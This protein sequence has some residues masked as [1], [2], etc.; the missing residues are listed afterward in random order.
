MIMRPQPKMQPS[1]FLPWYR[2]R[3]L[4]LSVHMCLSAT[5][6]SKCVLL[7]AHLPSCCFPYPSFPCLKCLLNLQASL[8]YYLTISW[9]SILSFRLNCSLLSAPEGCV[10]QPSKIACHPIVHSKFSQWW[11]HLVLTRALYIN[12]NSHLLNMKHRLFFF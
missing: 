8:Q 2:R 7:F 3:A 1:L 9:P 6:I 4:R 5:I 11:F 10:L 12:S